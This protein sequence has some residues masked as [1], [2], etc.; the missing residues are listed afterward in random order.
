MKDKMPPKNKEENKI[1]NPCADMPSIFK[2]KS[3]GGEPLYI[4]ANPPSGQLSRIWDHI[5]RK[6]NERK[7]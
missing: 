5:I 6:W 3:P 1:K 7:G 4:N 2:N